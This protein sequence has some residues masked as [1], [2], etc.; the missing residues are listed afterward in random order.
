MQ[1][2][3]LSG[4]CNWNHLFLTFKIRTKQ[5][6]PL[7]CSLLKPEAVLCGQDRVAWQKSL[8]TA[9]ACGRP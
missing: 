4:L 9:V 6:E 3:G 8:D 1:V 7:D 5:K 2:P